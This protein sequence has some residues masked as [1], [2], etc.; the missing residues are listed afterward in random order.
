V[1]RKL[2]LVAIADQTET[3]PWLSLGNS[4]SRLGP[5]GSPLAP[6]ARCY[7]SYFI[8]S[9]GST[10]RASPQRQWKKGLSDCPF[11]I[12]SCRLRVNFWSGTLTFLRND[13]GK[14]LLFFDFHCLFDSTFIRFPKDPRAQA[15]STYFS[16]PLLLFPFP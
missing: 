8:S 11:D 13:G 2:L 12:S 6:C 10:L 5:Q 9:E 3:W 4:S 15:R 7:I 1:D 16:I 14:P